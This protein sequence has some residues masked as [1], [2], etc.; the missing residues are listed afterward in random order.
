M[1]LSTRALV[2]TQHSNIPSFQHSLRGSTRWTLTSSSVLKP[3]WSSRLRPSSS[4]AAP[5]IT[6]LR[7]TAAS[8]PIHKVRQ[9]SPCGRSPVCARW[10]KPHL[11]LTVGKTTARSLIESRRS[12]SRNPGRGLAQP[13]RTVVRRTYRCVEHLLRSFRRDTHPP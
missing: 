1:G 11:Q 2:L 8:A 6:R 9:N 3:T 12:P 10:E 13:G 5:W 7:P 4:A